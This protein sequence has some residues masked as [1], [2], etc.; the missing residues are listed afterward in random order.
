VLILEAM[1]QTG[2]ILILDSMEKP[3][4][5]L[6]YF[7]SLDAVKFRKPVQPGDQLQIEVELIRARASSY[8]MAGKAY[9]SG[10]LVCE[11]ELMAGVVNR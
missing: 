3:E 2:A 5:K 7:M 11:A 10:E 1:A 6:A 9:V 8:K 4:E